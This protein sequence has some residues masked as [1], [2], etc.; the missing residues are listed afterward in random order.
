MR[1]LGSFHFETRHKP[2]LPKRERVNILIQCGGIHV[3]PRASIQDDDT[4]AG[5]NRPTIGVLRIFQRK[6]VMKNIA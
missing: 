4:R 2:A 3:C 1:Y 5:T 6:L